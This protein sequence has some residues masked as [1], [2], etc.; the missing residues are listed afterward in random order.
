MRA[1]S[2]CAHLLLVTT[3]AAIGLNLRPFMTGVGPLSFVI[4]QSAGMTDQML[5][6]LTLVPVL[7]MGIVAFLSLRL[8]ASSGARRA[9]L[10]AV[11]AISIGSALRAVARDGAGMIATAAVIGL[12]VAFAQSLVPGVIKREFP[13][14]VGSVTGLYS[15]MMM[16]GGALGALAS[17]RFFASTGDPGLALALFALPSLIGLGL[18][19]G[20]LPRH[21]PIQGCVSRLGWLL[22]RPRSYLLMLCFGLV[23]G[24]YSSVVAW[25]AR[26]LQEQGQSLLQS[27]RMLAVLAVAQ[28]FSA[29]ILPLLAR[30]S[31]DKRHW[32]LLALM[33]Q[34]VG[35]AGL[36]FT[37]LVATPIWVVAIGAGLGGC[38]SLS[39]IVA[40]DHL[41]DPIQAGA[42][43]ALMQGGGFLIASVPPLLL[44]LLHD[45]TGDYVAGWSFHLTS[46]LVVAGLVLRLA[47]DGYADA[48]RASANRAVGHP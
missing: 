3:I 40:L 15:C 48:M 10:L 38:F 16:G 42:L 25:L 5:A 23:N 28:A 17:P 36:A 35:F 32:L 43:S 30:G 11:T 14:R 34:V 45:R 18:A 9:I 46:V 26:F 29:L 21:M 7:L 24:G 37:P 27:G 8:Q 4:R 2:R 31:P 6:I 41:A 1:R 47:P 13:Q 22:T 44:A 19:V 20:F 33:F 39:L 12:G